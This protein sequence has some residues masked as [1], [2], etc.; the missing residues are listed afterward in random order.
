M[1]DIDVIMQLIDWNKS[2]TEQYEGV[3]LAKGVKCLNVF[4]Q[5]C[6]KEYNK[7]VWENCALILSERS[8]EELSP[9]VLELLL[10]LQDLNWP[11]AIRILNRLKKFKDKS[12]LIRIWK[13]CLKCA[14]TLNEKTWLNNLMSLDLISN[15]NNV[16]NDK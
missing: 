11:G 14:K 15:F 3:R 7:N 2:K 4:L 10:W 6:D 12:S 1:V 16:N 5:P 9:Y 13:K 8:D